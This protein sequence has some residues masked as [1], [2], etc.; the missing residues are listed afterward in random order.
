[1]PAQI[2]ERVIILVATN[3]DQGTREGTHTLHSLIGFESVLCQKSANFRVRIRITQQDLANLIGASRQKTW[4]A[5]KEL[6]DSKVLKLIYRSILVMEPEKLQASYLP[7]R[8]ITERPTKVA[9]YH[10]M[11]T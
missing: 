8:D 3:I 9:K 2:S 7:G 5:L 10:T 1:V 11:H 6:E 4:E